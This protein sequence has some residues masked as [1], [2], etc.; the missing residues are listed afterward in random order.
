LVE[1]TK[2][3]VLG[4]FAI[5]PHF[6][7]RQ[8]LPT[9]ISR[10]APIRI[11]AVLLAKFALHLQLQGK[12]IGGE[13]LLRALSTILEA[14][15]LVGGKLVV[16]EAIDEPAALFYAKYDFQPVPNHPRRLVLK[17]STIAKALNLD[18][19]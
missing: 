18:W 2:P 12:G 17:L 3:E 6:V 7:E 9:R 10:G 13:F 11:P 8:D 5:A 4:Y 15:R 19:P 16:V 14:G 1:G